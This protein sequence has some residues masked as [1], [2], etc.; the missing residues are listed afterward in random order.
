MTIRLS[1][2]RTNR[3]RPCGHD[4]LKQATMTSCGTRKILRFTAALCF[5]A[6]FQTTHAF[7]EACPQPSAIKIV[8][9][10]FDYVTFE[11]NATENLQNPLHCACG[12]PGVYSDVCSTDTYPS[13]C[14][15]NLTGRATAMFN[16]T[17]GYTHSVCVQTQCSATNFSRPF[18]T[19][20]HTL[21]LEPSE[22][23]VNLAVLAG[24]P[25]Q[26]QASWTTH[27][28]GDDVVKRYELSW[29]KRGPRHDSAPATSKSTAFSHETWMTLDGL[30]PH[31]S[32]AVQVVAVCENGNVTTRRQSAIV[33]ATT[34]PEGLVHVSDVTLATTN[35][36]PS[37]CDVSVAWKANAAD[38]EALERHEYRVKLCVGA[39]DVAEDCRNET[40]QGGRS[41]VSFPGVPN[42]APLLA[43]VT[44][45]F[46]IPGRAF[47]G[48]TTVARGPSCMLKIPR[49]EE[50]AIGKVTGRSARVT[51]SKLKELD[52]VRGAHY[53]LVVSA[54]MPAK[55]DEE[56]GTDTEGEQAEAA[57]DRSAERDDTIVQ[58]LSANETS[59]ELLGLKPWKNYSVT[60]T[61]GVTATGVAVTGES[62]SEVFETPAGPPGKPRNLSVVAREGDL[63]LTWLGPESWNGPRGG[64]EGNVACVQDNVRVNRPS[65]VLGPDTTEFATPAPSPGTSC[66]LSV[67][68][69]NVYQ[70]KSLDGDVARV[71]FKFT[72]GEDALQR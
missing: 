1:A 2:W 67:H 27:G 65:V 12:F 18:C 60:V 58:N 63:Y 24:S 22:Y 64:Y 32:Y 61:P 48:E 47:E 62:S 15:K 56:G 57:G 52:G 21:Y 44:P 59:F 28:S 39:E 31:T 72:S 7:Q 3:P 4:A 26:L 46:K 34:Y 69:F 5:V 30:E 53:R 71:Q 51:W 38:M 35:R 29:W 19:K 68:A 66:T 17:P 14:T 36:S 23:F 11:W 54:D 37:L 25:T 42:F 70:G 49:V 45:V 41:R 8:D 33:S 13:H 40:V 9:V 10:G 43:A 20:I 50:L 55:K 16:L 6:A